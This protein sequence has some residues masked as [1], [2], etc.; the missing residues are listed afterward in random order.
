M[1]IEEFLIRIRQLVSEVQVP[2]A[3]REYRGLY[4]R[5]VASHCLAFCLLNGSDIVSES[6]VGDFLRTEA[7]L[8]ERFSTGQTKL[9]LSCLQEASQLLR[10]AV[11]KIRPEL[12]RE[13]PPEGVTP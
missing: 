3:D 13:G 2:F 6:H 1:T 12:Y 9:G 10:E 11:R 4:A 8:F 5:A 7:L